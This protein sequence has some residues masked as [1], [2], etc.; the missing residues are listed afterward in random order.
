MGD[1]TEHFSRHEFACRCGCGMAAADVELLQ[2]LEAVRDFF[3]M[4]ITITGPCRCAGHNAMTVGASLGSY[5]TK[6]MAADFTVA[7]IAAKQVAD[8]LE[9]MHPDRYGIGRYPDRTHLDVRPNKA[10]WRA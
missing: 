7:G 4:P 3:A 1:L 6:G 10:R 2:V 5:H 8:Y 9:K